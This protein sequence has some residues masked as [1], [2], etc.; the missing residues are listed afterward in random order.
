MTIVALVF[1]AMLVRS[2]DWEGTR[3]WHDIDHERPI[4]ADAPSVAPPP[5]A[6]TKLSGEDF[7]DAANKTRQL[8]NRCWAMSLKH[9]PLNAMNVKRVVATLVV[10]ADGHV[11]RVDL[12][13]IP[14]DDDG[15]LRGCVTTVLASWRLPV[16]KTA[17]SYDVTL[18]FQ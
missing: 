15:G 11:A 9:Q 17:N 7:E 1:A 5:P 14:D 6:K 2:D 4:H 8:T 12:A 13:G 18:A 16:A 10:E 3:W